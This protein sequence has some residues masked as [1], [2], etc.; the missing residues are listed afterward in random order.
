MGKLPKIMLLVTALISA[1]LYFGPTPAHPGFKY[2][3][4]STPCLAAFREEV[5]VLGQ[6]LSDD[7]YLT[8][9]YYV[10]FITDEEGFVPETALVD[11][12]DENPPRLP[13]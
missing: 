8:P 3:I 1:A 12:C 5:D 9:W 6:V 13:E 7:Q 4:G 10:M 11:E 2:A